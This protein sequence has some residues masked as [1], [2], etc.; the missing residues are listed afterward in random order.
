M[1]P[2]RK[3]LVLARINPKFYP[4]NTV[5][6]CDRIPSGPTGVGL[7]IRH[8][9]GER[10]LWIV[11]GEDAGTVSSGAAGHPGEVGQEEENQVGRVDR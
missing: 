8:Q 9:K 7:G 11:C 10:S 6:G 2:R 3:P 4:T 1:A 5:V